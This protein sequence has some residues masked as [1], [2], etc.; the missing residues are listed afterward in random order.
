MSAAVNRELGLSPIALAAGLILLAAGYPSLLLVD[1][2]AENVWTFFG[3]ASILLGYTSVV[4]SILL[5]RR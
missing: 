1:T 3:C 2:R 5:R 4:A